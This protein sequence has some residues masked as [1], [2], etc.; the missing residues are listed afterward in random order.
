MCSAADARACHRL[1]TDSAVPS[2]LFCDLTNQTTSAAT[3]T[4]TRMHIAIMR[5][6]DYTSSRV[7]EVR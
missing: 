1:E 7:L 4:A 6:I 2:F 5:R 3:A